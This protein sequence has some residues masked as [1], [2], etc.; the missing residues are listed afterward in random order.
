MNHPIVKIVNDQGC[1]SYLIGSR[2]TREAMLVDP[3]LGRRDAYEKLLD[4][5]RLRLVAVVDTHTHADHLSDSAAFVARGVTLYMAA[6]TGCRRQHVA[7]REGDEI[8]VGDL[9]FRALEVPGHTVDSLAL[10]GHGLVLTGDSLLIGG[11]GRTDFRGSDAAQQFESV[12][13]KLLALPDRTLVFPGHGYRDVLFSTIGVERAKNPALSAKDG[14]DYA[15]RAQDV[16]GAGNTPD[17]DLMLRLNQEESPALPEGGKAVVACCDA[18]GG[19]PAIAKAREA[20]A[21]ELAPRREE[22]TAKGEWIDVR[23]PFE[24]EA[25]HVPGATSVPLGELGFHLDE[26]RGKPDL[27]VQCLGGV[28]SMTA[29]RTLAYLGVH[30]DPVSLAGGF[31][32]WTRAGLPVET[33][34]H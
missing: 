4:R 27:V 17:V 5:Y 24:F 29:A 20:A 18:G 28:R 26:L 23:D 9:S 7:L 3:K 12:T 21:N 11:L 30:R 2:A 34:A 13:K 15:A 10:A 14:K 25:G 31:E 22:F 16:P 32:A 6:N 33:S 8:R 19:G 1:Y